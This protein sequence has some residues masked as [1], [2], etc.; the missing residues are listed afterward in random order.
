[1]KKGIKISDAELEAANVK[2]HTFHGD[3]NYS[4]D[5]LKIG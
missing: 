4:I 5:K 1:M 2:K 3:W